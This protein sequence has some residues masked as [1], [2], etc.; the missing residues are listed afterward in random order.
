MNQR[1]VH[2]QHRKDVTADLARD[3]GG[4]V[5]RAALRG[6]GIDKEAVRAEVRA[7]RWETS[8]RHT[9]RVREVAEE[10][11]ARHWQAVWES[12]TG[13]VLDGAASLAAQGMTGFTPGSIDVSLPRSSTIWRV[14]GVTP[15]QRRVLERCLHA[16][17][18]RLAPEWATIHAA[19]WAVG[20]E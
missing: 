1:L 11:A 10:P 12:G 14:D 15:H 4:V 7:K 18:P 9:I 3:H 16:G 6:A 8:G 19:Q 17:V 13:A 20:S 2:R 5:H